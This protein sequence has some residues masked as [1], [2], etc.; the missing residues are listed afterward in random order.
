MAVNPTDLAEYQNDHDLLIE[1]RT[2]MK[3]LRN[4]LKVMSDSALKTIGDH[5]T[6][7][8]LVESGILTVEVTAREREKMTRLGGAILIFIV[9]VLEFVIN[10]W[11]G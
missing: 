8:R 5:E 11:A 9:G 3:G 6:R 4:D 10:K 1:L 7:L 2:E